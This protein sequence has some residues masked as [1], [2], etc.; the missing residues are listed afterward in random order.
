[1][2]GEGAGVIIL[3][4]LQHALNRGAKI[5]SEIIAYGQSSDGYHL[6]RPIETGEGGLRAM[7][8]EL[9]HGNFHHS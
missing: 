4:E 3:E 6:T 1:M 8:N 5:Y 9:N 7:Q 2:L